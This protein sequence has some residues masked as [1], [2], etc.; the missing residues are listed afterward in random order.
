MPIRPLTHTLGYPRIG[1]QRE[2]KKS[3][4]DYWQG[5]ATRADLESVARELRRRHWF[6]QR[7]AGIDLIPSND[8]SFYDQ[9]LDTTCLVGNMPAR[10]GWR[11]GQIDLDT[12]FAIARGVRAAAT[13]AG[14]HSTCSCPEGAATFAS[15]M[16]KW[17]DTNYQIRRGGGTRLENQAG[18][19]R[20]RDLPGFRQGLGLRPSQLRPLATVGTF[21]AG[22]F[23][24]L[25]SLG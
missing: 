14:Q 8:F 20:A 19:H 22:L 17:F 18:A 16:T 21:A 2:L 3:I 12:R 25:A 6:A 4:E 23:A 7:D 10:F 5:R 24:G 11:G 13:P 15:E 9:V 1:A